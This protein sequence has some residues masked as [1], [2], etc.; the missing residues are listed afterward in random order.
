MDKKSAIELAKRFSEQ[1]CEFMP[2]QRVILYGSCVKE[3]AKVNSDIDIAV[4]VEK[5]EGDYLNAQAKLFRLRRSIDLR[6]EPIIIEQSE[7]KSGFLEE[8]LETG[9]EIHTTTVA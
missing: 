9:I 2:V 3:E 5:L 1:V 7:D 8:I 6:I 4:I